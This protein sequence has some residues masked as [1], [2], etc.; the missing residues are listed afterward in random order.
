MVPDFFHLDLFLRDNLPQEWMIVNSEQTTCEGKV[1]FIR[2]D[3]GT[4]YQSKNRPVCLIQMKE[5][6]IVVIA[7]LI[8]SPAVKKVVKAI[9]M[10]IEKGVISS[11]C[12]TLTECSMACESCQEAAGFYEEYLVSP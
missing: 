10:A 11:R 12:L 5:R 1:T 3:M 7:L 2:I 9:K 4:Q 6:E 8:L